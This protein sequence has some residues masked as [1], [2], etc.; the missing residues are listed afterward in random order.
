M[1][2]KGEERSKKMTRIEEKGRRGAEDDENRK[3]KNDR[4]VRRGGE[5]GIGKV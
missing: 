3:G 5:E 2:G 1:E 4:E